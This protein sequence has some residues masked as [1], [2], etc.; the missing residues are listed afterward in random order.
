MHITKRRS[1][2]LIV[3]DHQDTREMYACY[4]RTRDCRVME[5][6][7][8]SQALHSV[9]RS[10]PAAIVV[11][12]SLPAPGACQLISALRSQAACRIP[13]I[14]L[15]GFGYQEYSD[16][17]LRAGCSCVLIKPCLPEVLLNE[18]QRALN[19]QTQSHMEQSHTAAS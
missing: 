18:I 16:E 11:D 7:N 5:A 12:L 8:C 2:I 14:G 10:S 19:F 4:L 6:S 3:E 1:P 9:H 13:I 17:A 15:N